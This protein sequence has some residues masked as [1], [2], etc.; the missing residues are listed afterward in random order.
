MRVMRASDAGPV[1][2]RRPS[3]G[4]RARMNRTSI[5]PGPKMLAETRVPD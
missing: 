4:Y 2:I 5:C 3:T 1:M